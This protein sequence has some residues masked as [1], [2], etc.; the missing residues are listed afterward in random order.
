MRNIEPIPFAHLLIAPPM[1]FPFGLRSGGSIFGAPRDRDEPGFPRTLFDCHRG[2]DLFP[3]GAT[4]GLAADIY[5]VNWGTVEYTLNHGG[6]NPTHPK[7]HPDWEVLIR[8]HPDSSGVYTQYRHLKS[9]ESAI[10]VGTAI[11]AGDRIGRISWHYNDQ[12]NQIRPHLHFMWAVKTNPADLF[13][14]FVANPDGTTRRIF[15]CIPLD[16]T[17]LLYRFE[18]YKW[19]SPSSATEV[20][21]YE[22]DS[23]LDVTRIR[24]ISWPS[25]PAATWLL[26]V[27]I[28]TDTDYYYLPIN[29]ALPH[30][31]AMADIINDAFNNN[32]RVKLIWRDSYFY[33]QE[34]RNMI[35]EV[36]VIH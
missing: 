20:T 33:G 21:R 29:D 18:S 14:D 26:Q 28:D 25:K 3:R 7:E 22:H 10:T 23:Y 1:D 27:R 34:K 9:L 8:H 5:A 17:P 19:R 12:G 4:G 13:V 32:L 24:V 35:D 15:N 2:I 6:N 16:P 30:E 31:Q 36:R 11:N